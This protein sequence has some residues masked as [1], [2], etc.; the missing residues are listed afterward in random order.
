ML[1]G[2]W[3]IQLFYNLRKKKQANNFNKNCKNN[4]NRDMKI[5]NGKSNKRVKILKYL[6]DLLP[7]K[8]YFICN[9]IFLK[10]K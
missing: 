7:K 2:G 5:K 3:R 10:H 4:L 8:G 6:F 1:F 9:F